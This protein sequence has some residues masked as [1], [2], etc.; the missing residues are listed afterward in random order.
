MRLMNVILKLMEYPAE[1]VV[2]KGFRIPHSY[3]VYYNEL[4]FEPEDNITVGEMR[5][6]AE[7]A[8][9]RTFTG[10][11]GGS[12]KMDEDT[13]VWLAEYGHEGEELGPTL[14]G[15]MLGDF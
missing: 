4:A 7:Y 9:N 1:Q 14:L 6:Q 12:Y 10:Y 13:N 11:K 5:E 3:R 8:L 2:T 15:Y